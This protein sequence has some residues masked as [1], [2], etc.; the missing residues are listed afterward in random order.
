MSTLQTE[1]SI[2][3]RLVFV[4]LPLGVHPAAG[5]EAEPL[6]GL[7][8][9]Q[10]LKEFRLSGAMAVAE[11]VTLVRDRAR[12]TF[13]GVFHFEN[14]I[15]GKVRSA[16]FVGQG[17][18]HADV[19][20]TEFERENVRRMLKADAVDSDFRVAVLRFSDDT[21]DFIGNNI[22]S[23][24]SPPSEALKLAEEFEPRLLKETGANIS[25]R[26]AVSILNQEEPGFFIA[27]FDKGKRDRF[28]YVLDYQGRIP[29]TTFDINGGEK[30]LIFAHRN[31]LIGNDIWMAFYSQEDYESGRVKYSDVFD[32]VAT[33]HY[34]MQIDVREPKKSLG[35]EARLD[36]SSK[37]DGLRAIPL[38]INR[39]LPEQDSVRLKKALRLSAVR[40]A[41]GSPLD[42]A[43]EDWEGGITLFLPSPRAAGERFSVLMSL[44][45]DSMY[46]S[47]Y[48][49]DCY[50]PRVS[51]DWYPRHGYLTRS[52]FDLT[53]RHRKHF[54]V[55]AVGVRVREEP[56]PGD[57]SEVIT[58]WKTEIPVTLVSFGVGRYEL[59]REPV[60]LGDRKLQLEFYSIPG[61]LLAIKED[62][63]LAEL[64]NSVRY[65][66]ALFSPYPYPTF[67]A[68]FHP[69]AFGQGLASLVLLPASDRADK[70]TYSFIAHETSHQW[71][72]NIVAWRSYRDQWLS[73]GFA[74]YSG[75]LY[76]GFRA[77]RKAQQE[78]IRELRQSLK[79]S[80]ETDM[81]FGKG[82]IANIGSLILGHR[83]A[84]R[85]SQNAYETLIYNKG[86]LVLR[87]VHFLFTDPDT[88]NGKPFLDMMGD[89]VK[90]HQGGW[91]TTESFLQ[92]AN[93]HFVKTPIARKYNLKDLNWFFHQ[94][95]Y[96][97][98]LPDYRLEYRLENQPDGSVI[99]RGDVYQDN[100]PDTWFMPLPIVVHFGKDRFA[101]G[102]VRAYGPKTAFA[103]KLPSRPSDVDLD[104][105]RWILSGET[106]ARRIK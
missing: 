48:I 53:F 104:P 19:P 87:M 88:G 97:A 52:T 20:R 49:P 86:A 85:Q 58:Q 42:A 17:T 25:A 38:A 43:Q 100:V 94:W 62:F 59:H 64:N 22:T 11:N 69:R 30:G 35:V 57:D 74:E 91:A 26:L 68:V 56:A 67:T 73:E 37:M 2:L 16:V 5:Q 78:L 51:G 106:D 12:M 13:D 80:P 66:S 61:K 92:V 95:V 55:A 65:F 54:R 102:V 4:C 84:T 18:F 99:L 47:P 34:T 103:M 21:L 93:E 63:I 40:F 60:D 8:V 75:I 72:G 36:F 31:S 9:Y 82:K 50:Y 77:K 79:E 101:R 1:A 7:E 71:W 15:A 70:H 81:G 24:G 14:P 33:D 44:E 76:T 29:T 46:D 3:V 45:G 39:S 98:E 96:Q 90:R 6:S 89:F 10:S 32:V 105:E 23:G 41:D 28:T 83:L 27:Q